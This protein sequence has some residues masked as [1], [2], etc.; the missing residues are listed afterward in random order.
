M[1][2]TQMTATHLF[3][4]ENVKA[5]SYIFLILYCIQI[6]ITITYCKRSVQLNI[7]D[8]STDCIQLDVISYSKYSIKLETITFYQYCIQ[9]VVYSLLLLY[10]VCSYVS[11][12]CLPRW[13]KR[14]HHFL[15][16]CI[17]LYFITFSSYCIHDMDKTPHDKKFEENYDNDLMMKR[18]Q[19]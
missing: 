14:H 3:E 2:M 9:L 6:N 19:L 1:L 11:Y 4:K 10:T 8:F 17:Q 5:Y 18:E 16:N 13:F 15:H 12:S 7:I